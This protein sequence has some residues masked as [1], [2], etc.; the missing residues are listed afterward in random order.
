MKNKGIVVCLNSG[1]KLPD[2]ESGK[3][4]EWIEIES[5]AFPGEGGWH[6]DECKI[7]GVRREYDTTD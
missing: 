2:C 4:H 3:A 7:C 5:P 6:T 1:G